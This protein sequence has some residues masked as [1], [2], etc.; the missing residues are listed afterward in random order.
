MDNH[1]IPQDVTGF[2]FRLIGDMTVKQFAYLAGGSIAGWILYS[3]LPISGLLKFPLA[4]CF[5]GIGAAF[6]FL[7]IDG[8]PMDIMITNFIRAFFVPNLY[9]YKKQGGHI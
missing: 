2:Q 7:P 5:V 9:I 3:L 8:R 6:A 1:P 4:G